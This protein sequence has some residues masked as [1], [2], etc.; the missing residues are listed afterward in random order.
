M[1]PAH[2]AISEDMSTLESI[3]G[4]S[5]AT[6]TGRATWL[7]G[8]TLLV[9]TLVYLVTTAPIAAAILPCL[10]GGW[11]PFRTGLWLLRSDPDRP[12]A[13]TCF[14]FYLA[15]ACW[16]A[17]AAALS[18]VVVFIL[19]ANT[20]GVQPAMSE[21]VAIMLVLA[22]GVVLNTLL[23]WGAICAA[24][25]RKVRVWVHP[26]LL[27]TTGGDLRSIA[28][29]SPPRSGFNQ[30][31]FVVAT[32]LAFPAVGAGAIGLAWMTVGQNRANVE[33]GSAT[34]LT[35]ALVFGVPL[36]M[37]PCYAWLSSRII[38][39]SPREC[40]PEMM[41]SDGQEDPRTRSS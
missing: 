17:A 29:L 30:A 25:V 20:I 35:F 28:E 9:A 27:A 10:H 32:A 8:L 19:A 13:R 4:D 15:A 36:A 21:F 24:I 16:N 3:A 1:Y 38:A 23:G 7:F 31:I 18:A 34:I 6:S 41:V 2:T 40:W 39:R 5:G 37:I 12:R 26:S 33:T 14:A 11:N 22:G